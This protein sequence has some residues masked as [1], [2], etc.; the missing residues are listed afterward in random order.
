VDPVEIEEPNS[1]LEAAFEHLS[2]ITQ[3][4]MEEHFMRDRSLVEIASEL[5]ENPSTVRVRLHRGC[6]K[7]R[8]Q[9]VV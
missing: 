5:G 2:E 4:I 7:L 1:A 3:R 9:L 6:R 8:A